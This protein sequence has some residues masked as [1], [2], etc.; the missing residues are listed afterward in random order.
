M[1]QASD[2]QDFHGTQ[3]YYKMGSKYVFTDG[4]K[5]LLDQMYPNNKDKQYQFLETCI[6]YN[7]FKYPEK[8]DL[9]KGGSPVSESKLCYLQTVHVY[10]DGI[11]YNTGKNGEILSEKELEKLCKESIDMYSK[12]VQ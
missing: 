1:S 6:Y 12:A 2:F 3:Q 8:S 10:K 11:A 4:I 5:W 9:H 7:G